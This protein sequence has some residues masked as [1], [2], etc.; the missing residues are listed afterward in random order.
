[1]ASY[2]FAA[3]DVIY[4]LQYDA[5]RIAKANLQQKRDDYLEFVELCLIFLNGFPEERQFSFKQPGAMHRAR[6]MAKAIYSIEIALLQNHIDL[7]PTG[8]ITSKHQPEKVRDFVTFVTLI[9]C[10]WW[11]QCSV[12]VDAPWNDLQLFKDLCQYSQVSAAI[13]SSAVKAFERHLWYLTAEM[14]P[15]A[16]FS[17]AQCTSRAEDILGQQFALCQTSWTFL[18]TTK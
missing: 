16:L 9:Y 11:L 15:L 6:W 3:Q 12:A 14:I 2:A 10:K 17:S 7:L 8:K 5:I 4:N 18:Q 1:M 13:S